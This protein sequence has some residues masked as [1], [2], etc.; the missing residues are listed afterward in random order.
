MSTVYILKGANS[1]YYIGSTKDFVRRLYYHQKGFVKA[2]RNNRP[3]KVAYTQ[4][5]SRLVDARRVE[6]KL[7]RFKN[8]RIIDKIVMEQEIRLGP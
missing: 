6:Y 3:L 4:E 8:K 1:N 7:K 5:Y 2:T